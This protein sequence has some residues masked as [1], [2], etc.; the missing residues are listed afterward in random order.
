MNGFQQ[1]LILYSSPLFHQCLFQIANYW[2]VHSCKYKIFPLAFGLE[3]KITPERD[4]SMT[5]CSQAL[6]EIH[7][8]LAKCCF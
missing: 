3:A 5:V 6:F 4:R 1:R 8:A 2:V 7:K